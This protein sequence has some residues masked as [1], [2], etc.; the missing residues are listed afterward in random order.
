MDAVGGLPVNLLR[1]HDVTLRGERLVLR[2]MCEGDWPALLRWNNDPEV[3]YFAEGNDVQSRPLEEV[4]GIYRWVSQSAFCFMMELEGRPIGECSLQQM[5]LPH[6][7]ERYSGLD[8][9]RI[10]L[11]IGEKHLWGHGLGTEAIRLLCAFGFEREGADV[12]LGCGVADYNPRSRR[13]FERAGFTVSDVVPQQ[14]GGKA[15]FCYDLLLTRERYY[16][17]RPT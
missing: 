13:A 3:L 10:D 6:L 14:P 16:S 15:R 5:N 12:I 4:Q 9:R 1:T 17:G 2:P 8:C 7:L 11:A